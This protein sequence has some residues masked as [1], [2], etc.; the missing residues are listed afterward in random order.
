MLMVLERRYLERVD[1]RLENNFDRVVAIIMTKVV[2]WCLDDNLDKRP[3]MSVALKMLE[4][5][6]NVHEAPLRL[7]HRILVFLE[8]C[9]YTKIPLYFPHGRR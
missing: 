2:V 5:E 7:V 3:W 1:H 8:V 9:G 4:G 6:W